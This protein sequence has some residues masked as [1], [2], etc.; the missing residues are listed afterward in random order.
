MKVFNTALKYSV[1]NLIM[2]H[3]NLKILFDFFDWF[4]FQ[5]F[6]SRYCRSLTKAL[7]YIKEWLANTNINTIDSSNI[8]S[9]GCCN[10]G[11]NCIDCKYLKEKGEYFYSYVTMRRY[12]VRQNVNCVSKNFICL[13]TC[14][15]CK[16]QGE[17]E[18]IGFKSWMANYRSCIK[19]K[20]NI[21]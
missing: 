3:I 19:N 8:V 9:Y 14:E 2:I 6:S 7:L 11:R 12:K 5:C 13:V 4:L 21:S 16:K 1:K 18:I 10:C 15:K 20:N 17:G